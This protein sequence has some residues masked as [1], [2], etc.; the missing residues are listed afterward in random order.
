M[1]R[2]LYDKAVESF[3]KRMFDDEERPFDIE[4]DEFYDWFN[5]QFEALV[6]KYELW[7]IY[8]GY[9]LACDRDGDCWYRGNLDRRAEYIGYR[10]RN[11]AKKNENLLVYCDVCFH[12]QLDEL[13]RTVELKDAIK[14]KLMRMIEEYERKKNMTMI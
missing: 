14:S 1:S 9:N 11:P 2:H 8:P 6:L 10:L 4:G 5:R 3:A 7:S 12:N 13:P